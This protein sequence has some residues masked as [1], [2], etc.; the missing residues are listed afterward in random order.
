MFLSLVLVPIVVITELGGPVEAVST[1]NEINPNMLNWF[2]DAA[3]SQ[4]VTIIG[5]I[6]LM[7]WGLGYFGQPHIIVRFMAISHCDSSWLFLLMI[8]HGDSSW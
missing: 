3:S 8:P 7:A 6:S 4:Q 1:I 2:V 5:I